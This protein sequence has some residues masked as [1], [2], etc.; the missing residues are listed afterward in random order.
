MNTAYE[1]RIQVISLGSI[2]LLLWKCSNLMKEKGRT[3]GTFPKGFLENTGGFGVKQLKALI[4]K[5]KI[6]GNYRKKD[7]SILTT[8]YRTQSRTLNFVISLGS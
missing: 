3:Q 7:V 2:F 6:Q 8:K 5:I 4:G 1:Q